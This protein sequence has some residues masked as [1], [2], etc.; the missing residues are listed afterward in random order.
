MITKILIIGFGGFIGSVARFFVSRL[1]LYWDFLAIPFGTLLVNI[2]GSFIIGFLTGISEKSDILTTEVRLFLMVGICGSFTT[3]SSFA[4]ENLMLMHNGQLLSLLLYT[5]LSIILGFLS[6][7]F[8][9][10]T[11]NLL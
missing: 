3:F 6:V 9:Y 4:N 10:V 11:T 5:S 7:Y 8:G 2:I 1:N